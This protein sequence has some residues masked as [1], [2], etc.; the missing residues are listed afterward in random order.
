MASTSMSDFFQ[1]DIA[2]LSL[3]MESARSPRRVASRGVHEQLTSEDDRRL[4]PVRW[5]R[6]KNA[7]TFVTWPLRRR[8]GKLPAHAAP[9]YIKGIDADGWTIEGGRPSGI[10]VRALTDEG[11]D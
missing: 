7:W 4:V 2:T 9:T 1:P 5:Q 11:E 8:L 6:T 10:V 3:C